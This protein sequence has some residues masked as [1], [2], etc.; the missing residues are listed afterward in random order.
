MFLDL[1]LRLEKKH[2]ACLDVPSVV[3]KVSYVN[4]NDTIFNIKI[5]THS[6]NNLSIYHINNESIPDSYNLKTKF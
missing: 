2:W 6:S 5:L 1:H 4:I 3:K